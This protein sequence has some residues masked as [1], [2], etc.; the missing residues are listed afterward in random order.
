MEAL[1]FNKQQMCVG[2]KAVYNWIL[3]ILPDQRDHSV[4]LSGYVPELFIF[5]LHCE[6][7]L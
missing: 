2:E 4:R 3:R 7:F 5:I 1:I 6:A